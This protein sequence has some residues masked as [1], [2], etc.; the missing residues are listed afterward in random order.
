MNGN[1]NENKQY[2]E[3]CRREVKKICGRRNG[4][5]IEKMEN[6]ATNYIKK[7]T[8]SFY[9]NTKKKNKNHTERNISEE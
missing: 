1:T 5:K 6:M 3:R 7:Q 8:R 2:Y 9:S 4:M